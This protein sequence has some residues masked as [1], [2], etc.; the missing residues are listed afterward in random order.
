MAAST[1]DSLSLAA[2]SRI[3]RYC[4]AG[5]AGVLAPE[6]VIRHPEQAAGEQIRL[7]AVI[8]KR[9]GLAHQPVDDVT[10]VHAM[11][12]A[13][14]QALA[15]ARPSSVRTTPPDGPRTAGPPPSARS[16]GCLPSRRCGPRG[17]GLP[18]ST[19]ASRRLTASSRAG[20]RPRRTF[21]S[22]AKRDSPAAVEMLEAS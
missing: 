18:Q 5:A 16:A 13:S 17:S 6:P 20:G 8:G 12:V 14:T 11:L 9:A 1:S 19:R 10:V 21:N 4:L 15:G 2:S 7:I 3:F 22:S